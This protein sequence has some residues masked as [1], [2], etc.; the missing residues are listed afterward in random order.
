[1][2]LGWL[3]ALAASVALV[4]GTLMI[5]A[6][7]ERE[8][9]NDRDDGLGGMAALSAAHVDGELARVAAVLVAS[10]GTRPIGEIVPMLGD[11]VNLCASGAPDECVA[12]EPRAA[13]AV[14]DSAISGA[15]AASGAVVATLEGDATDGVVVVAVRQSGRTLAAHI[16]TRRLLEVDSSLIPNR[17]LNTPRLIDSSVADVEIGPS[18]RGGRRLFTVPVSA[19]F[20]DGERYVVT[21]APAATPA[22]PGQRWALLACVAAGVV[23]FVASVSAL[24]GQHRRLTRRAATDDLTGLLT[25]R[26]FERRGRGVLDS[27]RREHLPAAVIFI[28]LDGFKLVNDHAGHHVGDVVLKTVAAHLSGVVRDSDVIARWG[29]DEFAMLLP[30]AGAVAASRRA[31]EIE[32]ALDHVTTVAGLPVTASVGAAVFPE[33]GADLAGLMRSADTAMYDAKRSGQTFGIATG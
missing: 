19:P 27:A 31:L 5:N 33:H 12:G 29:G 18:S 10:P 9:R 2:R 8:R 32:A 30:G 22:T 13:A 26:E 20:V 1:M 7:S 4:V 3:V 28:D 15:A 23:V 14:T 16:A 24:V 11:D 21:S 25:R 17:P 6:A